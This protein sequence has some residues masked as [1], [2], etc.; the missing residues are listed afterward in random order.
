M[1]QGFDKFAHWLFPELAEGSIPTRNPSGKLPKDVSD[2]LDDVVRAAGVQKA[3]LVRSARLVLDG[4]A[5]CRCLWYLHGAEGTI[6][7]EVD[8]PPELLAR[9]LFDAFVEFKFNPAA[10]KD[11]TFDG[12]GSPV[13]N[14]GDGWFEVSYLYAGKPPKR[15]RFKLGKLL[16]ELGYKPDLIKAF[17]TRQLPVWLWK[18]STHPFDVLTMSYNRPWTSCMRPE[19]AAELGPLT[20]MA[21]CSAIMFFYRPGADAP[22]GRRVLRPLAIYSEAIGIADGGQTYGNGPA[23]L[24]DQA[25]VSDMLKTASGHY[26]QFYEAL[27]LCPQGQRGIALT[28]YIYS[29]TDRGYCQQTDEQYAEAYTRL[30]NAPWPEPKLDLGDL[31]NR[32]ENLHELVEQNRGADPVTVARD[33]ADGWIDANNEGLSGL[34]SLWRDKGGNLPSTEDIDYAREQGLTREQIWTLGAMMHGVFEETVQT[35]LAALDAVII[36][37]IDPERSE[38][39]MYEDIV[40]YYRDR[41]SML[42]WY[43]PRDLYLFPFSIS[44]FVEDAGY[45]VDDDVAG[46][47]VVPA[48][49]NVASLISYVDSRNTI[50]VAQVPSDQY[51]FGWENWS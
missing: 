13:L 32:A 18:I 3:W 12:F 43:E 50:V 29:D 7:A 38:G 10:K 36:I 26:E 8:D 19:G 20:D 11:P 22:C 30:L 17:E 6:R 35:E 28:R 33:L 31:G 25:A 48:E 40:E 2:L 49:Q 37:A 24:G 42:D 5:G 39:N 27:S 44:K 21:A 34:I 1:D 23:H 51:T 46:I 16:R 15:R 14:W 4:L 47:A 9:N 41:I 45:D